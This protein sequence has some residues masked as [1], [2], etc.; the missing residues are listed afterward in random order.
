MGDR[1]DF[2]WQPSPSFNTID[3][4]VAEKW[5]RMKI[6]PSELCDE[7]EFLRRVRLDLTGL[8]PTAEE[9]QAFLSDQRPTRIK[10]QAKIDEL[11]GSPDYVEH[12]TNKWADLLQV[13]SK[14]SGRRRRKGLPRL[15]SH[16]RR[17]KSALRSDCD[18]DPDRQWIQ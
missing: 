15:D 1:D 2:A 3:E 6:L 11:I 18:S 8:P 5:E 10:R 16:S 17:R 13:N 9:L 14:F 12:W 7:H 4:L